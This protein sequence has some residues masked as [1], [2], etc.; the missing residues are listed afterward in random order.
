MTLHSFR[1]ALLAVAALL[2]TAPARADLMLFP[3]RVVFEPSQRVAQLELVNDGERP[4]TYRI[5]LVN[6]RMTDT[7]QFVDIEQAAPGEL[8]ADAMLRYSPHQVTLQPGISQTIRFS[9]RRPSELADGEYRSHLV[10]RKLP[11]A[12]GA[13]S[14]EQRPAGG[15]DIG[16]VLTA[17]VGASVP[18]IVRQGELS[19]SNTLSGLTLSGAAP[20]QPPLAVATLERSGNRSSYGDL[21]LSFARRG[22]ASEELA[23]IGGVA[24][25]VP[26]QRR[27]LRITPKADGQLSGGTLRLEYRA[28]R[29]AG[30]ALLAA[31]SVE[32]P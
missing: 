10:F 1:A 25:Y 20:G 29:E 18:V 13:T 9:L 2:S 30:G 32:L 6:K 8:F 26:N 21:V 23:R 19:A 16:T 11:E 4:A 14:V 5:E 22:G 27:A 3:T 17:L 31:T 24:L 28:A 12:G 7:G 15:G